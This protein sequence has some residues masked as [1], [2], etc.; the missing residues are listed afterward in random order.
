M[1]FVRNVGYAVAFRQV[2][3]PLGAVVGVLAL[4]DQPYTPKLLG[5]ALMF[6]GLVLVGLG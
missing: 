1:A 6:A 2:S 3:V 5:V 4:H